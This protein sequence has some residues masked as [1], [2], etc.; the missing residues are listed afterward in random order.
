MIEIDLFN[1]LYRPFPTF[2][3][4]FWYDAY[5]NVSDGSEFPRSAFMCGLYSWQADVASKLLASVS[6]I[7]SFQR[8][9]IMHYSKFKFSATWC[10]IKAER[11]KSHH[12]QSK[13]H[14]S[15]PSHDA[16][17]TIHFTTTHS[18]AKRFIGFA[19]AYVN[20]KTA[21]IKKSFTFCQLDRA[22]AEV[23]NFHN[24]LLLNCF[25]ATPVDEKGNGRRI[26]RKL[27]ILALFVGDVYAVIYWEW[28]FTTAVGHQP[29][30]DTN[31]A[32]IYYNHRSLTVDK[33]ASAERRDWLIRKRFSKRQRDEYLDDF[34]EC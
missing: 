28:S 23:N 18:C 10:Q 22:P 6:Q 2:Y 15:S 12:R 4:F 33:R 32:V 27:F 8:E 30:S 29:D 16:P 11:D 34:F 1:K 21:T 31:V 7:I 19:E 17:F 5:L 13:I 3:F 14:F 26:F 24:D 20:A 25:V 9:S